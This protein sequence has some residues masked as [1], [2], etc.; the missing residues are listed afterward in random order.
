MLAHAMMSRRERVSFAGIRSRRMRPA[1]LFRIF[2]RPDPHVSVEEEI[3]GIHSTLPIHFPFL[4]EI[5]RDEV[6]LHGRAAMPSAELHG[7]F[8]RRTDRFDARDWLATE[9]HGERAT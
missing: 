6:V 2:N 8:S 3:H 4:A 5:E 7:R 9:S 1:K